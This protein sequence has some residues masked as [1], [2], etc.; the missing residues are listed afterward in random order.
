MNHS[1][2]KRSIDI[3]LVAYFF[4]TVSKNIFIL[5]KHRYLF[6]RDNSYIITH[7]L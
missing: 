7:N 4:L 2:D 5:S 6:R 3:G 1:S